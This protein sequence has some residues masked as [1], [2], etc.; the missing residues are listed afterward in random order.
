VPGN[1]DIPPDSLKTPLS[2]IL[3][4]S[5]FPPSVD[6]NSFDCGLEKGLSARH[7][8]DPYIILLVTEELRLRV[9]SFQK[10]L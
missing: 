3:R 2:S 9:G 5:F 7:W 4:V 10:P 1:K 8:S 6:V